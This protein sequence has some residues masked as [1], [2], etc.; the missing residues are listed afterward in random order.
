ME[1][2]GHTM[3]LL[4]RIDG[5]DVRVHPE[6]CVL[7]RNRNASCLRCAR[8]CTSGAISAT[9]DG[10]V[11]DPDRCI[12]CGTCATVCP[13]CALEAANP[14][15][16]AL[17]RAAAQIVSESGGVVTFACTCAVDDALGTIR[18]EGDG[19]VQGRGVPGCVEVACLGRLDVTE[20]MELAARGAV[21]VVLVSGGCDACPHRTGGEVCDRTVE[22]VRDLLRAFGSP[23]QVDRGRELAALDRADGSNGPVRSFT[24]RR[25]ARLAD[26]S[27]EIL[28]HASD[29]V[30][31]REGFESG[32]YCEPAADGVGDDAAEEDG[33]DGGNAVPDAEPRLP[34]VGRNGALPQFVPTRRTRLFNCLKALG[35]PMETKLATDLWGTVS[36]DV[37]RCDSCRMC[38]VFCPTGALRRH[39]GS[40]GSFGVTHQSVFCVQCDT[41][42]AICPHDAIS[43]SPEVDLGD[44]L[45][46][47]K[48]LLEMEEP[49]WRPNEPDSIFQKMTGVLGARNNLSTY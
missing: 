19:G 16:Q 36:V 24:P 7:V 41:C 46:G 26:T 3:A 39:N 5:P 25:L 17:A 32:R 30:A 10:L 45:H 18:V 9:E 21:R 12:G 31:E 4:N 42:M 38:A 29:I 2:P 23:L 35:N 47:T 22:Q 15:D 11:V 1:S 37:S 40:D 34:K 13:T 8:A 43:V 33:V 28:D 49:S 20:L 6:R 48:V 27:R 44:F 14:D